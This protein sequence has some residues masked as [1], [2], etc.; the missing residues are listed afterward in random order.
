MKYALI[1]CGRIAVNHMKALKNTGLEL[2]GLCDLI[3]ENIDILL[4]KVS[5]ATNVPRYTDYKQM[6]KNNKNIDIVAIATD[7][8]AHAEI[9]LFCME[10]GI[11]VIVEKPMAM[12]MQDAT[13]MIRKSEEK[14]VKLAVCHQNRFNLAVQEMRK[15][16]EN[17]RFGRLSHGSIN[18][19]WNR[20]KAYYEQ[21]PWRGKWVSDGGALM[22][23][24]IHG[25][26]LLRWMLGDEVEEVYG[27]TRQ[28]FH[29]YLECE[30][31]GIALLKFENG[32][33]GS[34][35]G[36][37]NVYP[38]NLEETLYLFGENGT[39]KLGGTSCNNIDVWVF[40]DKSEDD[41]KVA[42]LQEVTSNVYGNGH[43]SLYYDVIS[44]IKENRQPY[45]DG[46]AGR[47]ALEIVLAIYKSQLTGRPVK[48]PLENFSSVELTGMFGEGIL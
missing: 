11:N 3:P 16:V 47:N 33:I 8:G 21:A 5:Y 31:V 19:R 25:I 41:D 28:Q 18:V 17:G 14:G 13:A 23:Q 32:A 45:I 42:G 12:S 24:C 43:T 36:T 44:A 7:S 15:A 46:Y 4:E 2:V 22:N 48:L 37:V 40:K 1:G 20:N 34:I 6:I 9:G 30:D 27:L 35:E 10:H 26:D 38:K 29:D 39:V